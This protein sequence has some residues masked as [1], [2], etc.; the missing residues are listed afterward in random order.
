MGFEKRWE[1]ETE[2]LKNEKQKRRERAKT[3][4]FHFFKTT[5]LQD[6]AQNSIVISM[7]RGLFFNFIFSF[8]FYLFSPS[9]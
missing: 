7:D 3:K 4:F 2:W 8:V 5:T 1:E 9:V 6:L